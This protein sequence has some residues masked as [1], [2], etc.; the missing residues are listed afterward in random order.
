MELL[1]G[2]RSRM[3]MK[4]TRQFLAEQQF[5]VLP[6]TESISY[7]AVA[8]IEQFAPSDGLRVGDAITAAT[9]LE[10]GAPLATANDRH[11]RMISG[12]TLRRF[13]RSSG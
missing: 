10:H 6:V 2:T 5:R 7:M 13:R 3:E 11:F 1:Q 8:L 4:E 9:A 12:L